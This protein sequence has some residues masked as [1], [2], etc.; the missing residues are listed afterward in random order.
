MD[1]K[2]LSS[3]ASLEACLVKEST[4]LGIANVSYMPYEESGIRR[5]SIETRGPALMEKISYMVVGLYILSVENR[6]KENLAAGDSKFRRALLDYYNPLGKENVSEVFLN[7]AV[8]IAYLYLPDRFPFVSQV[9]TVFKNFE[10]NRPKVIL[11]NGSDS[12]QSMF[13]VPYKNGFKSQIIIP[14]VHSPYV[15]QIKASE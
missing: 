3:L 14:V 5:I 4:I 8:E 9:L 12:E 6:F 2:I 11:E 7:S 13:L 1:L 10:L 15:N